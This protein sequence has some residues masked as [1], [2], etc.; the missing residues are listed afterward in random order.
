VFVVVAYDIADDRRR[1]R[2]MKLLEGFGR[3]A[4]E[5]VFECDLEPKDYRQ[6]TTRLLRLLN[7]REDNVRL[8]HLCASDVGRIETLGVGLPVEARR[9]F[10]L[11]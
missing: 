9:A 10:T 8:Y 7:L 4:Q 2:V 1:T 5:S 6:M 11:V 3:H